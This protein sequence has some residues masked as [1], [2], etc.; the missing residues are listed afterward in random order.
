MD[1]FYTQ[2]V[3]SVRMDVV[4]YVDKSNLC[5]KSVFILHGWILLFLANWCRASWLFQYLGSNND[6]CCTFV[7]GSLW[8][9]FFF[10]QCLWV[11]NEG[12]LCD[13]CGYFFH[14]FPSPNLHS[15]AAE[16]YL[17]EVMI[18]SWYQRSQFNWICKVLTVEVNFAKNL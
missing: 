5:V 10:C 7:A 4:S 3:N 8:F 18:R 16:Y 13:M 6:M 11:T 2:A 12:N 17:F 14:T 15:K 9:F 1:C